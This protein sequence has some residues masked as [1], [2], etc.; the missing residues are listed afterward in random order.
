MNKLTFEE[1]QAYLQKTFSLLAV[2]MNQRV[3]RRAIRLSKSP[4]FEISNENVILYNRLDEIL[5][6]NCKEMCS[7]LETRFETCKEIVTLENKLHVKESN[8]H[9]ESL[10]TVTNR[11][12]FKI[13]ENCKCNF[14]PKSAKAIFCSDKCRVAGH[15]TKM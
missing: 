6:R 9:K 11:N 12:T 10:Q 15:R 14:T 7:E 3:N 5:L 4:D 8:Y 2:Y 13:C 1:E